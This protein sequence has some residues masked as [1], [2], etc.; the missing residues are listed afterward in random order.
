MNYLTKFD[1]NGKRITSY[2]L[3]DSIDDTKYD[4]LIADGYIEIDEDEWNYYV[5]NKGGG[6]NGTGYIR[7]SATGKP[8]SA[9]AHVPSKEEQLA[10]LDLQYDSDKAELTRYFTDALLAGDTDAQ[11]ELKAE[12]AELD[13]QYAEQRKEIEE[14]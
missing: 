7:D 14:G 4:E 11:E 3:D 2:P 9:P 1:S 5:G 6:D 10:A 12:M 13:L 8:V